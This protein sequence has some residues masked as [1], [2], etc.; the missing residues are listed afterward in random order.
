MNITN[1]IAQLSEL[2]LEQN[3]IRAQIATRTGATKTESEDTEGD[4]EG[5]DCGECGCGKGGCVCPCWESRTNYISVSITFLT[6][7]FIRTFAIS[8]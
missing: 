1:I 8:C 5:Y 2:Q 3:K 7:C 4:S 6:V